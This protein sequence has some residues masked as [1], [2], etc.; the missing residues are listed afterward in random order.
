MT[1]EVRTP[2]L[3]PQGIFGQ[4]LRLWR[5]RADW[6]QTQMAAAVGVHA[7]YL[8]QLEHGKKRPSPQFLLRLFATLHRRLPAWTVAEAVDSLVSLGITWGTVAQWLEA[9]ALGLRNVQ[10]L[11]QWWAAGRPV[12]PPLTV[13][14]PRQAPFLYVERTIQPVIARQLLDWTQ[15][16]A[17]RYRAHIL[18]G[19]GGRGKT[20]LAEAL[21][22][23]PQTRT[24]FREGIFWLDAARGTPAEWGATLAQ[25]A[26]LRRRAGEGWVA[27]WQR[28]TAQ[29]QH[30]ALV[31][32]DDLAAGQD[33]QPLLGR[34]GPQ[35][36][37]L[38]TT[39]QPD[40]IWL[41]LRRW[42][43]A[44]TLQ[45]HQV[46]S[47]QEAELRRLAWH[48][49]QR[50]PT[51]AELTRLQRLGAVWGRAPDL[52]STALADAQRY[53]WATA[54]QNLRHPGGAAESAVRRHLRRL[55]RYDTGAWQA[56]AALAQES[57]GPHPF[58]RVFAALVW[59]T[60]LTHATQR[61]T[62]LTRQGVL[63]R[64][65][66]P[67]LE[68]SGTTG[69]MLTPLVR[70]VLQAHRSAAHLPP[71]VRLWRYW[72]LTRREPQLGG[73]QGLWLAVRAALQP[74]AALP[75]LPPS[76]GGRP[77][78][79]RDAA[80]AASPRPPTTQELL[81]LQASGRFLLGTLL[82]LS[83]GSV[84]IWAFRR[85][86]LPLSIGRPVRDL[87]V[88]WRVPN[89]AV[90]LLWCA[91]LTLLFIAQL[92]SCGARRPHP[93]VIH[94]APADCSEPHQDEVG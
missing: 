82:K 67:G 62:Q 76:S 38:I 69:W 84:A 56:V 17:V 6:S 58:N 91:L 74:T 66:G 54:E 71:R 70:R 52:L 39:Q 81:W 50:D 83:V 31:I 46:P 87:P 8:S 13:P 29:P 65:P 44:V 12:A 78:H 85:W 11:R 9:D 15:Y 19:L 75:E 20:T 2:A 88:G 72:Q 51:R 47:L 14:P 27:R 60:S 1:E 5:R 25:A 45:E 89:C 37:L 59:E 30:R 43:P 73:W 94:H 24:G 63:E 57:Q 61:L 80:E 22:G 92:I 36:V 23:R 21:V 86:F 68:V 49:W 32:L 77:T 18:W 41:A 28:W 53:G 93:P 10:S 34:W 3:P 48:I 64:S 33:L 26:G 90:C 7:S 40:A 79:R 4:A 55:R 42:L 16:Q 35:M